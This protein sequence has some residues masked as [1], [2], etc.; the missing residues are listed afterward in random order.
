MIIIKI[1]FHI[2]SKKKKKGLTSSLLMEQTSHIKKNSL[3]K[4]KKCISNKIHTKK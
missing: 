4:I 1:F 3:I 2:L